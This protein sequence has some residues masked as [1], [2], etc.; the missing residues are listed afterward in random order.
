MNDSTAPAT[1]HTGTMN[2]FFAKL[3]VGMAI[4]WAMLNA[5]QAFVTHGSVNLNLATPILAMITSYLG[6][7]LCIAIGLAGFHKTGSPFLKVGGGFL[8]IGGLGMLIFTLVVSGV[9]AA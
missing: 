5:L 1:G 9:G 3:V 6:T 2:P 4:P 7:I 8:F